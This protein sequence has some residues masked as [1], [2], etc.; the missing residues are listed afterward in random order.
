VGGNV[1]ERENKLPE[2]Q[3]R[4]KQG[5][6]AKGEKDE[7]VLHFFPPNCPPLIPLSDEGD[8]DAEA[9]RVVRT[10]DLA[11]HTN[12]LDVDKT[13]VCPYTRN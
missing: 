6:S 8:V 2:E 1:E 12:A 11:Q 9:H 7:Y 3:G 4:L 10:N 13:H 5:T